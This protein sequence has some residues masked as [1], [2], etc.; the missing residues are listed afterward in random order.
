MIFKKT[1][2][3]SVVAIVIVLLISNLAACGNN[4]NDQN[5]A[6]KAVHEKTV[7]SATTESSN[8]ATKKVRKLSET[9]SA[10]SSS[11]PNASNTSSS[12]SKSSQSSVRHTSQI[13]ISSPAQARAWV[14]QKI[15]GG[16]KHGPYVYSYMSNTV[17]L[18]GIKVYWVKGPGHD[19]YVDRKGN[20]YDDSANKVAGPSSPDAPVVKQKQKK[21]AVK[22]AQK[23]Y[24]LNSAD[25]A[26]AALKHKYGDQGW[27]VMSGTMGMSNNPSWTISSAKGQTYVIYAIDG[28]VE[29]Q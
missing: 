9:S 22:K 2:T 17:E 5:Q 8:G 12:T 1:V 14:K 25:E 10:N 23:K 7:Q 3:R 15:G 11:T 19:Y 27:N 13:L 16:D 26:V 24:A 4:N 21:P 29:K 6:K 28:H 20:I 18:K